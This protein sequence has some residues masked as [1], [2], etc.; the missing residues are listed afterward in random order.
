LGQRQIQ[1]NQTDFCVVNGRA[2]GEGFGL[3][4]KAGSNATHFPGSEALF[5]ALGGLLVLKTPAH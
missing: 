4:S 3:L 2:Y 1:E 5:D